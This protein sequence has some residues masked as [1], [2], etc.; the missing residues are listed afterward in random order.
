MDTI[1]QYMFNNLF[2]QINDNNFSTDNI[3]KHLS[4]IN[5]ETQIFVIGNTIQSIYN[6]KS[7]DETNNLEL[8][9]KLSDLLIS[10]SIEF[11]KK[12]NNNDE[13]IKKILNLNNNFNIIIM[14]F[15]DFIINLDHLKLEGGLNNYLKCSRNSYII[16]DFINI[17]RYN[18]ALKLFN[19]FHKYG[20]CGFHCGCSSKLLKIQRWKDCILF[21]NKNEYE[22][23][24]TE[25]FIIMSEYINENNLLSNEKKIELSN[26]IED[27]IN[28]EIFIKKINGEN[29]TPAFKFGSGYNNLRKF[30]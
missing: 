4:N 19:F 17:G 20:K 24:Q 11:T 25:S 18:D 29:V 7:L 13:Q 5:L 3:I 2:E 6:T 30:D 9:K 26:L 27:N 28:K 12:N 8:L 16:N 15:N 21:Y 23:Q 22:L 14:D 1:K 10:K